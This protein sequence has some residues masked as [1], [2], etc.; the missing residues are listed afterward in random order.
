MTS[1]TREVQVL[2]SGYENSPV[3]LNPVDVG[4]VAP[5]WPSAW[6][7]MMPMGSGWVNY[8]VRYLPQHHG[9]GE[10]VV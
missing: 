3:A 10:R 2:E 9:S 5:G 4:S 1:Q 7:S 8:P 6:S